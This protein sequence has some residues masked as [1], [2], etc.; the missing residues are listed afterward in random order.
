MRRLLG[1]VDPC[2]VAAGDEWLCRELQQHDRRARNSRVAARQQHRLGGLRRRGRLGLGGE[3][4]VL[5]GSH[6]SI[7][8]G[9][10][11]EHAC[12]GR[13]LLED[14]GREGSHVAARG[15][16]VQSGR[17]R[18]RTQRILCLHPRSGLG[19]ARWLNLRLFD[20][21]A[22]EL[23]SD[24]FRAVWHRVQTKDV[25][26]KQVVPLA[27]EHVGDGFIQKH[28]DHRKLLVYSRSQNVARWNRVILQGY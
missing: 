26:R 15:R 11:D 20:D 12:D 4:I 3:H 18:Q 28:L 6:N 1:G 9:P 17:H 10:T 19:R 25:G 16:R 23:K 14:V 8:R 24:H 2:A 13:A 21:P 22:E 7:T 27:R 5:E